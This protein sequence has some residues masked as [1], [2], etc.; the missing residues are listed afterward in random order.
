MVLSYYI[1]K[2]PSPTS[3]DILIYQTRTTALIEVNQEELKAVESGNFDNTE[4]VSILT[5]YGFLVE[6]HES[7]LNVIEKTR[8][9]FMKLGHQH[10]TI[11]TTTRCNAKCFYCFENGINH[12][13]MSIETANRIID[14]VKDTFE[15]KNLSI[16]WIGG[17]PLANFPIIEYLTTEFERNGYILNASVTT[18]GAL[19]TED[20]MNFFMSHSSR[21]TIQFSLDAAINEEYH[22][23]KQF[24][25]H[26]EQTSFKHVINN[27]KVAL[28]SGAYVDVRFNFIA[29]KIEKAKN[30]FLHV[31]D[32]LKTED[33][34][35]S[36]LF[37]APLDLNGSNEVISNF[38]QAMEHPYI[39]IVKHQRETGYPI[40]AELQEDPS[41]SLA[42]FGLMPTCYICGMTTANKLVIDAD[43]TLYKCH[44]FA[45]RKEFS[46]G[47]IWT[48]IDKKSKSYQQFSQIKITDKQC[49]ECSLLPVCQ[50]GCIAKRV[51]LG[52]SQKCHKAKQVQQQ[53][54]KMYYDN[55]E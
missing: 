16:L 54:V 30:T 31:L 51:M 6:S 28:R 27:I 24:E 29:S 39:Q 10:L 23:I 21:F 26:N 17:E 36:Y 3:G 53:L 1:I 52:D 15:D 14:F 47:S 46:C 4:L 50:T 40:R 37:L 41:D 18:N 19:L 22:R 9:E 35:K 38:H 49:E 13:D 12:Y 44:R 55:I 8:A 5:E 20:M 33:L 2:Q 25:G 42:S 34:S 45:G 11:L 43:G 7:E 32:L 48:G